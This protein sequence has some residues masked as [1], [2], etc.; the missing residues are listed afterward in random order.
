MRL[1]VKIGGAQ[2]SDP[3]SRGVLVGAVAK[4]CSAGHQVILVHGGGDQIR[5]LTG[6]L[7]IEDRYHEGLR[8]TDAETAEVVLMV[9]GGQVNR[10]LVAEL[11]R[12]GVPAV[13]LTGADG[14]LFSA[15]PLQRPGADLGF[16]GTVCQ[17]QP[18]LIE[19]LMAADMVPVIATVAPLD[20]GLEGSA[21]HF[22]NINADHCAGPLAQ[23]FGAETL[24]FL[25]NVPGVLDA[26]QQLLPR[27]SPGDCAALRQS[28]VIHGGMIPKVEA[29][30]LAVTAHPSGC[31][32]IA[33]AA[34]DNA[35][36]EA[37]ATTTGTTFQ[38]DT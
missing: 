34:G 26:D 23:A 29:A 13:G 9:L 2:L 7:G 30:L 33:P 22:Y 14:E 12:Q 24:L 11:S 31:I 18:Q 17:A 3:Q 6:R 19:R 4:A 5:D 16:V 38:A 1:L 8:I 37:L 27:L 21:E 25:T 32:K 10:L 28:G 36:L 35:V 15:A 20:R